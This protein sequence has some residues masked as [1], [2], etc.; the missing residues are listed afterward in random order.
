MK[1]R[2]AMSSGTQV[3][4]CQLEVAWRATHLQSW[5]AMGGHTQVS[6]ATKVILHTRVSI[7]PYTL[8]FNRPREIKL[9]TWLLVPSVISDWDEPERAPH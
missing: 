3:R 5:N 1:P 9:P 7:I 6:V 2:V 4:H 8:T